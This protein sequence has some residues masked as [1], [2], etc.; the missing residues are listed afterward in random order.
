M[1]CWRYKEVYFKN[2]KV[3]VLKVLITDDFLVHHVLNMRFKQLKNGQGEKCEINELITIC[4]QEDDKMNRNMVE[5][6]H[7]VVGPNPGK[8]ITIKKFRSHKRNNQAILTIHQILKIAQ[9][10]ES[11][12]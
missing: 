7:L 5:S 6:A 3:K 12:S 2:C 10:K 8:K 1:I 4:L 9:T 11:K